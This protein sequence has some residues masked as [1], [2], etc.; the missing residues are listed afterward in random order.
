[1][2]DWAHGNQL[3]WCHKGP[4]WLIHSKLSTFRALYLFWKY[5][6]ALCNFLISGTHLALVSLKKKW[7]QEAFEFGRTECAGA[8]VNSS[9]FAPF[10]S[11]N[12]QREESVTSVMLKRRRFVTPAFSYKEGSVHQVLTR[13]S[14]LWLCWYFGFFQWKIFGR[15]AYVWSAWTSSHSFSGKFK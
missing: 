8:F 9:C 10:P 14:S 11:V 3:P 6:T 15:A 1:M 7:W 5:W 2:N 4:W 12:G 13:Q